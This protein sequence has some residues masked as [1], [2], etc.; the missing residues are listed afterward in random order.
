[1]HKL[2][3]IGCGSQARYVIDIVSVDKSY[4]IIG[5]VD[6]KSSLMIGTEING[7]EV[8][9]GIEE[10]PQQFSA[11]ET[12][13]IV[14]H[15]DVVRKSKAVELLSNHRFSFVNT[16]SSRAVIS[17]F[18]KIGEGCIIGP[19]A[20]IQPNAIIGNHVIIHPQSVVEHDNQI[21]NYCNI[22]PG[23]SLGGSVVVGEKTYIYTGATVIPKVKIGNNSVVAA[24]AVVTEDVK[25]NEVVAGVPAKVIRMNQ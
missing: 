4:D 14:A 8:L 23:V 13:I 10:V 9:C 7:I 21:G 6:M 11:S 2:L 15:G 5:A 19:N 3:I 16:I 18:C 12:K 17:P 20:T 24:G 25:D 22:A 1:M